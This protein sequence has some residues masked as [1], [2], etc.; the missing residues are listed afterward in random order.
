MPPTRTGIAVRVIAL[1]SNLPIYRSLGT[2]TAAVAL[3]NDEAS[4][5]FPLTKSSDAASRVT[6]WRRNIRARPAI[7]G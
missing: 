5:R 1:K 4:R 3:R 7:H 2:L 6:L